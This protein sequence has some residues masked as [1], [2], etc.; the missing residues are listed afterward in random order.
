MTSQLF[1]ESP[2]QVIT[3]DHNKYS[4]RSSDGTVVPSNEGMCLLLQALC[5]FYLG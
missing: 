3:E 4:L 5:Y 1:L 2:A